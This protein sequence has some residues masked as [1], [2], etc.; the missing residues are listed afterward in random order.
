MPIYITAAS[1]LIF[2][3]AAHGEITGFAAASWRAFHFAP[4]QIER[5]YIV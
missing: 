1:A 2:Q 3:Y 5:I 4:I